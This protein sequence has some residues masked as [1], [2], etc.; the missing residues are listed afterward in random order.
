[1]DTTLLLNRTAELLT[2]LANDLGSPNYQ[3]TRSELLEL[4]KD[5]QAAEY[6]IDVF[7][8][9][10]CHAR[11]YRD[12]KRLH[13]QYE[14]QLRLEEPD[15]DKRFQKWDEFCSLPDFRKKAI[16]SLQNELAELPLAAPACR[17]VAKVAVEEL[18]ALLFDKDTPVWLC[19][20]IA[21]D[22]RFGGLLGAAV[23]LPYA[24]DS[25]A[26]VKHEDRRRINQIDECYKQ[27]AELLK[28]LENCPVEA[29]PPALDPLSYEMQ[30]IV[31]DRVKS[32]LL[33][34]YSLDQLVFLLNTNILPPWVR[35]SVR[36]TFKSNSNCP[37]LK[38]RQGYGWRKK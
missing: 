16:L 17:S 31:G 6:M 12:N 19:K 22:P 7:I 29:A 1:M 23:E 13:E 9:G 4:L 2:S 28:W 32:D 8:I 27:V 26:P 36:Q 35:F 14:A 25:C 34:K 38:K 3:N 10:L 18:P 33:Q 37:P 11:K 5:P 15:I 24:P 21:G 20:A 30:S